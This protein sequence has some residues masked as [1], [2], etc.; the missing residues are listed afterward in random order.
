MPIFLTDDRQRRRKAMPLDAKSKKPIF[1]A[2]NHA[3]IKGK[4]KVGVCTALSVSWCAKRLKNV[5]D[6]ECNPDAT[7]AAINH[8][9][10]R[11]FEARNKMIVNQNLKVATQ[12]SGDS[13]G[14]ESDSDDKM[15]RFLVGREGV[16]LISMHRAKVGAGG[17][18]VALDTRAGQIRYYDPNRGMWEIADEADLVTHLQATRKLVSFT[19]QLA[20]VEELSR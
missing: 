4:P 13:A 5:S 3:P 19:S 8:V 1:E 14:W 10:T 20:T 9:L 17:H 2:D 18:T 15:A 7:F 16:Y 12:G 6:V 11:D